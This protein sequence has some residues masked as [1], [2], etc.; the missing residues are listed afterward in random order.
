MLL[1]V[2]LISC[3]S[4]SGKN[5]DTPEVGNQTI[6]DAV[7]TIT[8]RGRVVIYGNEP[9]TFTG[10]VA[11]DGT[12][13][14]VYPPSIEADLRGLQGHFIEFTAIMLDEPRGYGSLFLKGGTITP[15]SWKIL[16]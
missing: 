12:E 1:F 15:L 10:I 8:I 2:L 3:I 6:D 5:E 13:F 7:T 4:A 9:H 14:A 11:D 16:N